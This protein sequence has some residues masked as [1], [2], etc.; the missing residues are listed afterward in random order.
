MSHEPPV[1]PSTWTRRR[2]LLRPARVPG[3]DLTMRLRHFGEAPFIEDESVNSDPTTLVNF[4]AFSS[5]GRW[6]A[7]VEVFNL[8]DVADADLTYFY[9]SRLASEAV[10]VAERHFHAVEP[11]QARNSIRLSF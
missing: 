10:A 9:E 6:Q 1:A 4:G 11:R 7:G 5:F 2:G 3:F 8:F